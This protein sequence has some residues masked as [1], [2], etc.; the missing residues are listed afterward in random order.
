MLAITISV[1]LVCCGG[2]DGRFLFK[3]PFWNKPTQLFEKICWKWAIFFSSWKL[4]KMVWWEP[5]TILST[6]VM[7]KAPTI[8]E[9][10]QASKETSWTHCK[11]WL[12]VGFK[13]TLNALYIKPVN[14]PNTIN[15]PPHR[16]KS[17]VV[18][19][20]VYSEKILYVL[21][22]LNGIGVR[23][24]PWATEDKDYN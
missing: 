12:N 20:M 6:W 10:M 7:D 21:I 2:E 13:S 24:L 17:K 18:Q 11:S 19:N 23:N 1:R 15:S 16:Y 5:L 9:L 22:K 3:L 8:L 4:N 14:D